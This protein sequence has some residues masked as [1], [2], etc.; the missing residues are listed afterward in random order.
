MKICTRVLS[1]GEPPGL[2]PLIVA[3]GILSIN[4]EGLH[5]WVEQIIDAV[6]GDCSIPEVQGCDLLKIRRVGNKPEGNVLNVVGVP[7]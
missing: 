6:I 1:I 5:I 2:G 3:D 4:R 7:R